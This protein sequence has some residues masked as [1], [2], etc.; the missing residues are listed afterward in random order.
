[1]AWYLIGDPYPT[2][3]AVWA[4]LVKD[5]ERDGLSPPSGV[6]WR[7]EACLVRMDDHPVSL[8]DGISVGCEHKASHHN[9]TEVF[10]DIRRAE[11]TLRPVNREID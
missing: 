3:P 5:L 1:M 8:M 9:M 4:R 10:D 6:T 7:S 11:E 2:P